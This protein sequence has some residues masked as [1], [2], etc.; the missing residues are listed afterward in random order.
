MTDEENVPPQVT[1]LTVADIVAVAI[2]TMQQREQKTHNTSEIAGLIPE[3]SG[4]EDVTSWFMRLR[5]VMNTY[6]VQ[7]EIMVLILINKLTGTAKNGFIHPQ[8]MLL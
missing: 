5:T 2:E 7:E 8:V 1:Q 6:N 4:A 3:F